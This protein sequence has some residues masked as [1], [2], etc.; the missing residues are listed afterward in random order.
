M[1]PLPE[2]ETLRERIAAQRPIRIEGSFFRLISERYRDEIT[3][4]AGSFQ[5]GGRYNPKRGF[6]VLY[7][8]ESEP[9]SRAEVL[10]AAGD[11]A[12]LR[13][14]FLC[15]EIRMVLERVLDLT[16]EEVLEELGIRREELLRDRGDRERD[17]RLPRRI[18][19]LARAAGFE[20]LKVPSVT[21][22]GAN[23]VIF[24]E[25]LSV[26]AQLE[27]IETRPMTFES[28]D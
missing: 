20:A 11:P 18:A 2:D 10:R 3:S 1:T 9:V 7:L 14:P 5:H 28:K 8:S 17:Y 15:G 19:R 4:T 13:G 16:D 12:S 24:M 25:N 27:V 21:S 23:L 22:R 6:G 26:E